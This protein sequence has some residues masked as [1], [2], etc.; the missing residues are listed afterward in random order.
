[1]FTHDRMGE[2]LDAEIQ[3]AHHTADDSELL[4]VLLAEDGDVRS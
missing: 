3:I 4:V 1:M 2:D